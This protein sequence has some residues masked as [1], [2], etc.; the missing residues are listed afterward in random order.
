MFPPQVGGIPIRCVCPNQ[1]QI[2]L[3]PMAGLG[4]EE[5]G[6]EMLV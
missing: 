3:G 4:R 2:L 6:F 5:P 1:E